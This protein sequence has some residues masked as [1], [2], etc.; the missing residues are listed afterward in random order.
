MEENM[1]GVITCFLVGALICFFG[2]RN[3]KGDISSLHS[4]H[5]ARVSEE[6]VKPFG[7]MVG[8]GTL[9][10]GISVVIFALLQMVTIFTGR[11]IFTIVGTFILFVLLTVGMIITFLAMKKYNGGIF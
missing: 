4:Y 2:I 9:L 3:M 6:N 5:R 11:D 1:F 10:C 8:L 7:K